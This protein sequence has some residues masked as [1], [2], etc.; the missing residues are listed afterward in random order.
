MKT[1]QMNSRERH[2]V[3]HIYD[4][5]SIKCVECQNVF[6]RGGYMHLYLNDYAKIFADYLF[7][8]DRKM[9]QND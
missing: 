5:T 7:P 8:K 9:P 1:W 4:E 6:K 2:E 3:T